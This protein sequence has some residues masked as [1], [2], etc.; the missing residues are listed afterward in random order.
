MEHL[1]SPGQG[2]RATR[3]SLCDLQNSC[4]RETLVV[5]RR[6]QKVN[7]ASTSDQNGVMIRPTGPDKLFIED[8]RSHSNL[9]SA[10]M[11][12]TKTSRC[13]TADQWSRPRRLLPSTL[14]HCVGV[15]LKYCC[16]YLSVCA[17]TFPKVPPRVLKRFENNLLCKNAAFVFIEPFGRK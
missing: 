12:F 17:N 11:F 16:F 5:R 8:G 13:C 1:Q 15:Y 10:L 14:M 3:W 2:V 9:G 7:S 4:K 6:R